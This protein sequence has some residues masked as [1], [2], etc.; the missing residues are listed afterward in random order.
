M[1]INLV[2]RKQ[3][4]SEDLTKINRDIEQAMQ[5]RERMIGALLEIE[6]MLQE[7]TPVVPDTPPSEK[8]EDA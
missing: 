2:A 7:D 5:V 1:T 6:S 4:L 8:G 3:K